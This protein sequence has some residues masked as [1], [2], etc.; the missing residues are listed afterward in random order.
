MNTK[1]HEF[2]SIKTKVMCK[3]ILLF[4][5]VS[6]S[7]SQSVSAQYDPTYTQYMFNE[8]FINPAY[9]GTKEAMSATLMRRDQWVTFPGRPATT[10]FSLNGPVMGNKMGLGLSVLND[11]IGV[12]N[13]NLIYGSYAYR[14][15]LD[16]KQTLSFGLSAGI[17][18][19]TNRYGDLKLTDVSG[20]PADPLLNANAP[21]LTGLNFGTGMFYTT[22]TFYGG[23]SIPRLLDNFAG[24]NSTASRAY[25]I[26]E[27][28]ANNFTYYIVAGNVFKINEDLLLKATTM[29]K[30]VRDAPVQ[31]DLTANFLI[32]KFIWAGLD[33]RNN[34]AIAAI[35][36]WQV[37][38]QLMVSYSYDYGLNKIQLYSQ[39]THEIV[40]NYIFAYKGKNV[41]TPR[42]F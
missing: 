27:I 15:K 34:S 9:A 3:K 25:K 11:R 38:K 32:Q 35:L 24:F 31:M 42:Y 20:A 23:I 26:T 19:Q 6:L 37:N 29:F 28:R 41:V 12:F 1:F 36:G 2:L 5:I 14:L 33:Y 18:N 8:M 21:S 40:L 39:G 16:E 30:V 17:D 10:A 4:I 7:I 22:K 13:R